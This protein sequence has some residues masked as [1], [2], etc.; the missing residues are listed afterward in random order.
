MS[1]GISAV[2]PSV[3]A[4]NADYLDAQ[5]AVFKADPDAISPDLRSFFQGFDLALANVG[6]GKVV[7][8]SAPAPAGSGDGPQVRFEFSVRGL[9]DAY[10][11][12]GHLAAKLDPLGNP[13]GWHDRPSP[14]AELTLAYHGLSEGDLGRECAPGLAALPGRATLAKVLE[15]LQAV[16][17]AST[18]A[19]VMH[20][21]DAGERQW[22]VE[23]LERDAGR[24]ALAKE[25]RT[26][27][28]DV[29]INCEQFERFAENR[30]K[31]KKRFSVEGG[32]ASV[33]TLDVCLE[34]LS[35]GGVD[36]V[37][38]GMAHRGRL[39]VLHN[40]VEM[41]FEK[42]ITD[43]EESWTED[44]AADGG[45]V[46]YH[47][48]YSADRTLRN[49]RKMRVCLAPNPSHL[50]AVNP[51]VLGRV[52]GKQRLRGDLD[53]KA[54]APILIHGDA[55]VI[56]QG[57]VPELINMAGLEGYTVGGTVHI[58]TNNMLGFT[59]LPVD[60][61]T[62]EYCTDGAKITGCPVIHV[63]GEDPDACVEAAKIA[64]E[65]RQRFGKD[66]WIDIWCFRKYGHNETDEPRFTQPVMYEQIKETPPV[67]VA[68][69]KVLLDAGV[70]TEA[71]VK[72]RQ[73]AL[74][75]E[76]DAAQASAQRHPVP[77][78]V[79][80]GRGRWSK[81]RQQYSFEQPATG[82]SEGTLKDVV[83]TFA[84]L[85]E[86]FNPHRVIAKVLA[87][88]AGLLE[89]R[90]ISYA[91]GETLAFGTLLLEGHAVRLSGQDCRRGTFGH[92][93]AVVRDQKTGAAY[94]PLN[95]MRP[96]ARIPDDAGSKGTQAQLDVWDSPLSELAVMSF[97]YGVS[98]TDPNMLVCWEAQFG[99]FSNGAQML[100]D[101]FLAT[102]E[103][104]WERWSS[105]ALLLPHG[106]EGMGPEHTSCRPERFLQMCGNDN[107]Q[108][109]W[110]STGAQAF[111]MLRRQMHGA[112]R[113]PLVV[114]TPKSHLRI[115]TSTVDE[116][117]N[118]RFQT[119]IDD[120]RYAEADGAGRRGVK[121]VILCYGKYYHE[122]ALKR[123]QGNRADTA[124]V[125]VEQIYP[126]DSARLGR[127]LA[128]YP[129]SAQLVC[130]QEEP[131]NM[132]AYLFLAD[133]IR[134]SLGLELAYAGRA[135]HCSPASGSDYR[136]KATQKEI[137]ASAID[138]SEPAPTPRTPAGATV[139]GTAGGHGAG[140]NGTP[141]KSA[142]TPARADKNAG[143]PA[144]K[145]P[146]PPTPPAP[147]A[148]SSRPGKR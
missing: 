82:V 48:G 62:S 140:T 125:R 83:S 109:V 77:P 45:D 108:V 1:S 55:A 7:G 114:M 135:Q 18:G 137:L 134:Q 66:V 65:Y 52:R 29:L 35:A 43:F 133:A 47:R 107:M 2:K 36:E 75:K 85:P 72:Q 69:T 104:K 115:P 25:E 78:G 92:R 147:P 105:L 41:P 49:G 124:L 119:V 33:A 14:P 21:P 84:R 117:V 24:P 59:T 143:K 61:R 132:G 71:W 3:N 56:G 68:Y 44:F 76:L 64:A 42:L 144:S 39:N 94:M 20:V 123:E 12:F 58:V 90:K 145:P 141:G 70:V 38:M 120:P 99:D 89:T 31:G 28:L 91:D 67:V 101:Q 97:D 51:V 63:N 112:Y 46:K 6:T 19:E 17:T 87:D 126:F 57:S 136:T 27:V 79:P 118:G 34:A 80:P 50:E 16:Y 111:H 37:V 15:L 129:S 98:L 74:A 100:I 8:Q 128:Q 26:R 81:V 103:I 54:V 116:L 130:A 9:I 22:L 110:P 93:H 106:Q 13:R 10:R 148:P 122:L 113:K 131:R 102:G 4:W 30:Y 73:A 96:I 5:Y 127:V 95:A 146:T 11:R 86:G 60:G 138:W 32:E 121:R 53:R 23:R 40:I 88:R 142:P 139:N